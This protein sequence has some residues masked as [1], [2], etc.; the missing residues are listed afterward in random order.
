MSN[1]NYPEDLL[2]SAMGVISN[3]T[4]WDLVGREE[5]VEAAREWLDA[6]QAAHKDTV[7]EDTT[8]LEGGK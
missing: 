2:E 7:S 1:W 5:W 6:Y 8:L 4:D 3:A